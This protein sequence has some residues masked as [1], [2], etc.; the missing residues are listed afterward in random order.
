MDDHVQAAKKQ[1]DKITASDDYSQLALEQAKA[2]L[3]QGEEEIRIH[4]KHIQIADCSDWGAV[5]KYE[6]DKKANNLD[7]EKRLFHPCKERDS[8]RRCVMA[9]GPARKKPRV[10][11]EAR[12][13]EGGVRGTPPGPKTRPIRPCYNCSQWGHLARACPRN[14]QLYPFDQSVMSS[15]GKM[16]ATLCNNNSLNVVGAVSQGQG[17]VKADCQSQGLAS[18]IDYCQVLITMNLLKLYLLRQLWG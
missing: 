8:K 13:N 18:V 17:G 6:A 14:Q 7:D 3:K 1:L 4:Q 9:A 5:A 16:S 2:E 11:G 15:I 10:E 12:S